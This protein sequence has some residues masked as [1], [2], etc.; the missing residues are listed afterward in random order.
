MLCNVTTS[1]KYCHSCLNLLMDTKA[2]IAVIADSGVTQIVDGYN[3][4]IKC[5][6]GS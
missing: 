2:I 5:C 6:I 3:V 1:G 4:M